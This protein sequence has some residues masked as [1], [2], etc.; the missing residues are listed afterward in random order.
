[1]RWLKHSLPDQL[2]DDGADGR[3]KLT[4]RNWFYAE[5]RIH[6][7]PCILGDRTERHRRLDAHAILDCR[8][9]VLS[10]HAHSAQAD[11]DE[12]A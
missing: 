9:H 10:V 6:S 4:M 3:A 1:M 5:I 12:V 11:R 7:M 8:R 2:L